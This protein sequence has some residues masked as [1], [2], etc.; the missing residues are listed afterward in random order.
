MASPM[1]CGRRAARALRPAWWGA[2][3]R[4]TW[5]ADALA[6]LLGAVLVLP[7]AIAFATLAGLPPQYGLYTAIVPCAVA[8]LVGS[9]RHVVTGPTN[10]L[11]LALLAMLGPLAAPG[12]PAYIE[13]ALT[14]TVLVGLLQLAIGVLRLGSLAHFI[15]PA[16]LL[17][18]TGGAAVLIAWH[19]LQ[20][21]LGVHAPGPAP[22][23]PPPWAALTAG[24]AVWQ[25]GSVAVGLATLAVALAVRR[26]RPRWPHA[27]VGLV[28]GTALA[29]LL[30][31]LGGPWHTPVIGA[32]PS[33]WPAFHVPQ[34]DWSRLPE[35]LGL[36]FALTIVAL[37]QSISIAKALAARAGDRLDANREFIGQ[38]LANAVGGLFSSY[39]AC[40]SL[41][42]SL[43]NYEAG[44]RTPL[45]SVLS[46]VWLLA[47]VAL[48][49]RWLG[50]IPMAAVAGLL[51]LVAW[52]LLDLRRW[53]ETWV[54]DRTEFA[55]ALAT[56]VAT[57]TLRLE[58]A[59]LAGT[60]L[61]LLVYLHRTSHPA[62]RTM[63]FD[64]MAEDRHFVVVDGAD[65]ALPQCPQLKLLRM[66]GAVYFGAAQHVAD[67]LDALRRAPSAPRHLLVMAKS[68]N[69]IDLAGAQVWEDELRLRRATG[70]D[71]YFHRPRPPVLEFWQR[72]GFLDRL[73]RDHVFPDKRSAIATIFGRL[74]PR[75]C[76][77]CRARVF[78]EC[79]TAPIALTPAE[80]GRAAPRQG[81]NLA[82]SGTVAVD[83]SPKTE[84]ETARGR[85]GP[86]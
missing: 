17:G 60:I 55:V 10:A 72:S 32:I 44:A 70:G 22:A 69:F 33:A 38:G 15:S 26:Y 51:L 13:L 29:V 50:A 85:A 40:G 30:N 58:V 65:H 81:L 28:A 71:L 20:D 18:F 49:A 82:A 21:V 27:L 62:M 1:T 46:A 67:R 45:A 36:A 80:Q 75:I 25:E 48:S 83:A 23:G 11:S 16:A 24:R 3:G 57:V 54:L 53:R 31:R 34:V 12:T 73:G 84:A 79:R 59:I 74:D 86:A 5:R 42:R 6:G 14:V 68:M 39:V 4:D 52:N 41:N 66:E 19:A 78:W 64:T 76:A 37:G 8:A 9:S 56:L 77:A 47:L 43:P 2:L 63:G 7:Q 61:S 35:L